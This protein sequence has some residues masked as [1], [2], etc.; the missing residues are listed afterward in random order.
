MDVD[1][2]ASYISQPGAD[3]WLIGVSGIQAQCPTVLPFHS[4]NELVA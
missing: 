1:K 3:A 4:N 2:V